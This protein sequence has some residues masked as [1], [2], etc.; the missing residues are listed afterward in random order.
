MVELLVLWYIEGVQAED[1]IILGRALRIGRLSNGAMY[2]R[3]MHAALTLRH[4]DY[5]IGFYTSGLGT[6]IV[7]SKGND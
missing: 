1:G 5:D 6:M 7:H 4:R 2:Q 3:L